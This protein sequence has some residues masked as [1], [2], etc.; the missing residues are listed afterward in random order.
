MRTRT[1]AGRPVCLTVWDLWG[2]AHIADPGGPWGLT[3]CGRQLDGAGARP[4]GK[5]C[6]AC[7]EGAADANVRLGQ[8]LGEE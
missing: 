4:T 5:S 2:R 8:L 7:A 3:V 1:V 6:H